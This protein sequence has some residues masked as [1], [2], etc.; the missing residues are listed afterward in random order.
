MTL[1]KV[2]QVVEWQ[3]ANKEVLEKDKVNDEE[4]RCF[5][6]EAEEVLELK[7]K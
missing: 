1:S 5:Q 7:K 2:Q 6:A 3:E 4:R